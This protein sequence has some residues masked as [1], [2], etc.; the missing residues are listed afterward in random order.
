MM[1][2]SVSVV[3]PAYN[4]AGFLPRA[5]ASAAAQ[6]LQPL[7]ILVVDDG[8]SDATARI[9]RGFGEP[10]RL[11]GQ[12]HR[13]AAAARNNGIRAARGEVIAFL[14]ADDEWLPHKLENQLPLHLRPGLA[15]SYC[16][17]HEFDPQGRDL[18]D[19]FREGG[20]TRGNDLWRKLLAANF[21]AT[22][23]VMAGRA[24]L[25]SLGGF[26]ES[27]EV[28]EDQDMWIRL[29]LRGQVDFVEESLVRVHVRAGSL[30]SIGIDEQLRFTLPMI[31]GHLEA[32]AHRLTPRERRAIRGARLGKLG[33]D[34]Y[35]HGYWR[36]GLALVASALRNGDRPLHNLYHLAAAGPWRRGLDDALRTLRGHLCRPAS[37]D[38]VRPGLS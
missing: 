1:L 12:E 3:I 35:A 19:T 28:G 2:P 31:E 34:A 29:A 18:G 13:G 27:L 11:I 24:L 16:H 22:P 32:L 17:S 38:P 6:S 4:A 15:M 23:T 25:L 8:S 20:A 7:E 36:L 14:D 9:A 21:I 37:H 10:V 33:R 30:S 5:L 26:A